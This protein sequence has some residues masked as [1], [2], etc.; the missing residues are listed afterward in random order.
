M[1]DHLASGSHVAARD[2]HTLPATGVAALAATVPEV[3][4][5]AGA[6]C[7]T[8]ASAPSPVLT[9]IV[10]SAVQSSRTVRLGLGRYIGENDVRT[11]ARALV[12]GARGAAAVTP[13]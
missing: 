5:S 6:V 13:E 9:A 7:H 12:R 4:F 11:A 3:A 1:R 10:L 8:G 2:G